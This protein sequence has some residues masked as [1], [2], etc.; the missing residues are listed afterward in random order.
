MVLRSL[1]NQ[2]LFPHSGSA[3]VRRIIPKNSGLIWWQGDHGRIGGDWGGNK[4]ISPS[5][6]S[7]PPGIPGDQISPQ[8]EQHLVDLQ[9]AL[10]HSL[11]ARTLF[12]S[13]NN[14]CRLKESTNKAKCQRRVDLW[15]NVL[16]CSCVRIFCI[17][18]LHRKNIYV[19]TL[20]KFNVI[21]GPFTRRRSLW[22]RGNTARR[23]RLWRRGTCCVGTNGRRGAD[24]VP[25]SAP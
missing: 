9:G 7:N 5:I 13:P 17:L 23:H 15:P 2:D 6:S 11:S 4:L 16:C 24:V 25:S 19:W 8:G 20:E 18:I 21:F 14:P 10:P 22:R 12:S 1:W 3:S